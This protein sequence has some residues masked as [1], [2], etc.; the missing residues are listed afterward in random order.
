MGWF[1]YLDKYGISNADKN[2]WMVL[3]NRLRKHARTCAI[4]REPFVNEIPV[5]DHKIPHRGDLKLLLDPMNIQ[6]LHK[7]CHDSVKKAHEMRGNTKTYGQ[8]G[9][10]LD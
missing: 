4:C 10:P 5:M 9:W 3:R 8:D 6:P 7:K 2:R 1:T